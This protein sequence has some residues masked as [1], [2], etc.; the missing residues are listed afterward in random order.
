MNNELPPLS[1]EVNEK[2]GAAA[3]HERVASDH[4]ER[5]AYLTQRANLISLGIITL[6][7]AFIIGELPKRESI[8]IPVVHLL[9]PAFFAI[10]TILLDYVQYL[11]AQFVDWQLL[12][13]FESQKESDPKYDPNDPRYKMAYWLFYAKHL[14]TLAAS[15]WFIATVFYA[16]IS[17]A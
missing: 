6:C 7:W 10:I 11:L 9:G 5:T 12:K 15:I 4:K 1:S 8:S 14:S 3:F 2:A 16:L 13:R 17:V